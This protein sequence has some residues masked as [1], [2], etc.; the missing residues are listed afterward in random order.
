MMTLD[1]LK[2]EW[3]QRENKPVTP[4]VYSQQ[5]FNTIIK[6]R[7]M[8]NKNIAMQYFW[9]AF[10]LQMLVY[11]L[12]FHVVIRYWAQTAIA[13]TGLTGVAL[14]IPFTVMLLKKFKRI[15]SARLMD[16]VDASLYRHIAFCRRELQSFYRFKKH[17][18][19]VLVPLSAAI[20]T[21]LT[22]ELYVPGGAFAHLSVAV[23]TFVVAV[24][25]CLY[26]IRRENERNFEQPIARFQQMLDELM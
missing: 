10:A 13:I 3:G 20:G 6:S 9:A 22:F 18:E 23:I 8:K 21:F 11:A 26:A 1:K 17:Y 7:I 16:K 4:A 15:A 19:M 12:L 24:L 5:E 25:S 2:E 14:Y